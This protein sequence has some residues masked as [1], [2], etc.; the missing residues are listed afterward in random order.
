MGKSPFSSRSSISK[1][2][3]S[4]GGLP[5]D[6]CCEMT[7]ESASHS[8]AT[9]APNRSSSTPCWS[10]RL[11]SAAAILIRYDAMAVDRDG[12]AYVAGDTNSANFP[13]TQGA[14][15]TK[16]T[17]PDQPVRHFRL[18]AQSFRH[19]VAVFHVPGKRR[20]LQLAALGRWTG[21]RAATLDLQWMAGA[22]PISPAPCVLE[23][24][25]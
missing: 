2:T 11:I 18:E 17:N 8:V 25:P 21:S 16:Y 23:S 6:L 19:G 9:I 3:V 15:D 24:S 5:G 20:L 10:T 22:T 13:V 1:R 14:F 4:A 12:N 7:I